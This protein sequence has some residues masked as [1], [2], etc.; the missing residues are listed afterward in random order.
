M[1]EAS[2]DS[3]T[4]TPHGASVRTL[5]D[6]LT[7]IPLAAAP[8]ECVDQ[9]DE[10][11]RLKSA[12]CAT[13]ARISG[14]LDQHR[15][16]Q[17]EARRQLEPRR[18]RPKPEAGI[19]KEIGLARRESPHDGRRKL[20]LARALL[21]DLPETLAALERGDLN[22]RRAEI[23]ATETSCLDAE[24]RREVD[25]AV[26]GDLDGL[27]DGHLRD[28]VQREV[29]RRD[30]EGWLAR[31][32]RARAKRRVTG[33]ILGDGMGQLSA[34]LP[35][36]DLSLIMASLDAAAETA[37]S[38]GDERDR[39]QLVADTLVG[40]LSGRGRNTPAPTAIKLL[41]SAETLMGDG[42]EPGYVF[43]A[44]HVPASVARSMVIAAA[45]HTHSTIQRLFTA[46]HNGALV[47]MESSTS[48]FR[49]ALAE[50]IKLRDR[51]CRSPFC[52]APIRHVDHVIGRAGDGVTSS[53]NGQGLCEACNYAKEAH[54]WRHEPHRD[55]LA[56][57]EVSVT[58]P[59]G[60]VH[61]SRAPDP[62]TDQSHP[63]P[64]ERHVS[65]RLL[66]LAS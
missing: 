27:G 38:Q 61:R 4:L 64:A 8:E 57:T 25:A 59:T 37:R 65:A 39:S 14:Q 63:S 41:V 26:C 44:G 51:R 12:I 56:V 15:L 13:Q 60:H 10:L 50:F 34:T 48:F 47:A 42:D 66:A 30:E 46:P 7:T 29:L 24:K 19:A 49:G 16:A 53:D 17:D 40:R 2:L 1:F 43:S 31:H 54:G 36:T 52:S 28:L 11:E 33:R 3:P 5:R 20:A 45:G 6:A 35:A 18:R 21:H 22:E 32:E 23:I 9:L 62:P 58:T 55:P